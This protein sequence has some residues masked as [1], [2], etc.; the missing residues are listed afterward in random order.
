MSTWEKILHWVDLKQMYLNILLEGHLKITWSSWGQGYS[1]ME[2][3]PIYAHV[4]L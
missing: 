1:S 3:F 2:Q 4:C